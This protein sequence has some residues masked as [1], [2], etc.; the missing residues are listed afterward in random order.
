MKVYI[1]LCFVLSSGLVA[2]ANGADLDN[3]YDKY[4]E[5]LQKERDR[6]TDDRDLRSEARRWNHDI[7][8]LTQ[9]REIVDKV[10]ESKSSIRKEIRRFF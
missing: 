5:K 7:D 2:L 6:L 4:I 1:L 8:K 3:K 10:R 9:R